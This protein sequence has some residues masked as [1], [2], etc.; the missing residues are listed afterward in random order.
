MGPKG[1]LEEPELRTHSVEV[2]KEWSEQRERAA[3]QHVRLI[4]HLVSDVSR[5]LLSRE[6][7]KDFVSAADEILSSESDDDKELNYLRGVIS[8]TMKS[9]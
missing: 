9:L 3:K 6:D 4:V 2:F 1:P 8:S 7:A 5:H